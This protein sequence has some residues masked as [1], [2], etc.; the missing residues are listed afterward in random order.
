[1][2][3]EDGTGNPQPHLA[4]RGERS[5]TDRGGD[6]SLNVDGLC[7]TLSW[8]QENPGPALRTRC[9]QNRGNE[10]KGDR[11]QTWGR[12]STP[13]T[14]GIFEISEVIGQVT[15]NKIT[16]VN[17]K[18][19]RYRLPQDPPHARASSRCREHPFFFS[20]KVCHDTSQV[21]LDPGTGKKNLVVL[22]RSRRSKLLLQRS[23][24]Y[25]GECSMTA[26]NAVHVRR[27]SGAQEARP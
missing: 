20:S 9:R 6:S 18:M 3:P 12:I 4:P 27:L 13:D 14:F 15:G 25:G 1:M 7:A 26:S 19:P 11:S 10:N 21:N 16:P 23:Y 24:R 17:W 5:A 2:L 8:L 22:E